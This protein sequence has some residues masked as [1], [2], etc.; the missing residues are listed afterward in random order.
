MFDEIALLPHVEYKKH[1]DVLLGMENGVIVDHA[2][3]F[4]VKGIL[5]N[6]KQSVAYTFCKGTLT[7]ANLKTNIVNHYNTKIDYNWVKCN[8][9]RV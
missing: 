2:L 6:W 5:T 7:T 1:E 3:V 8:C 4:I 9:N